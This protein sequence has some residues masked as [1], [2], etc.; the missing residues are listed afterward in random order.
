MRLGKCYIEGRGVQRDPQTGVDW[1]QR[2]AKL[3]DA[4][5]LNALGELW[6]SGSL[7]ECG[8][9]VNKQKALKYFRCEHIA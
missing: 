2:A 9:P 8:Y 1:I 5:A 3:G 7:P 6:D 4:D